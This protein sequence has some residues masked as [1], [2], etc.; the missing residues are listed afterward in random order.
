M[1]PTSSVRFANWQPS[2][3]RRE[4]IHNHDVKPIRGRRVLLEL[5]YKNATANAGPAIG[6]MNSTGC[7]PGSHL[8]LNQE[9][10]NRI[11]GRHY[12]DELHNTIAT[13]KRARPLS[14]WNSKQRLLGSH[15]LLDQERNPM[16][17]LDTRQ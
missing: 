15:L 2:G 14:A 4:R 10:N 13:A 9:R 3:A 1:L 6:K 11:R 7:L 12:S 16:L 8:L 17:V 5:H